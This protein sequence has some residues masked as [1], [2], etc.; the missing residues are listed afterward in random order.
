MAV[1]TVRDICRGA[2]QALGRLSVCETPDAD[3]GALALELLNGLLDQYAAERLAIYFSTRTTFT[4]TPSDGSYTVG[5]GGDVAIVRPVFL[6]E[7]RFVDTSPTIPMEYPLKQLTDD[8]YRAIAMKTLTSPFPQAWYYN[9]TFTSGLGTLLFY[10]VP[11]STTITGVVYSPTAIARY[12]A[13][14][15]AFSLPPGYERFLRTNLA[16]ELAAPLE[17]EPSQGLRD[18]ARESRIVVFSANSRPAEMVLE[19]AALCGGGGRYDIFTD[20]NG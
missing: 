20:S 12:A 7:V 10:P 13:L 16:L 1:S 6:D 19:A 17:K 8:E 3:V 5:T 18:A 11:T 9:P 2:L 15:D 14:T 4:I